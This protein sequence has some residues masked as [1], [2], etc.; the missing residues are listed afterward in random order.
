MSDKVLIVLANGAEECEAVCVYDIL[1]RG[2]VDVLLKGLGERKIKL[3][4]SLVVETDDTLSHKDEEESYPI[5]YLPGG[6]KGARNLSE[7]TLL[8]TILKRTVERGDIVAAICASPSVVLGPL[9]LL[10]GHKATCYPS[11]ESFYPSFSFSQEGVV[12]SGN[13]ITAKSAGWAYDMAFVLL[14]ILK[15]KEVAEEVR[16]EIY[17]KESL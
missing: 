12:K 17:Y 2:G 1:K 9:G 11:C 4:H 14:E 8:S 3:S 13:I 10:E 7:S 6:M 5:V 15:G 16:K